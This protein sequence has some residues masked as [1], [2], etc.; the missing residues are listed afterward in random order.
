[1]PLV[2][3]VPEEQRKNGVPCRYISLN[4]VGETIDSFYRTG[5]RKDLEAAVSAWLKVTFV[6]PRQE[7]ERASQEAPTAHVKGRVASFDSF[8]SG[9]GTVFSRCA[10]PDCSVIFDY[11]HGRFFRFHKNVAPGEIKNTHSVQHF[12]LCGQCCP[13]FTLEYRA[14]IGVLIHRTDMVSRAESSQF[15]AAA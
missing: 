7:N 1:M 2:A 6:K 13:K 10:N 4:E 9:R 11:G 5:T 12:W 14:G 15:I 8:G 3:F